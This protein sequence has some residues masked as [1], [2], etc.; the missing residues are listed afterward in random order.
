[1]SPPELRTAF[2]R[3]TRL[4]DLPVVI[5][6]DSLIAS[7]VNTKFSSFRIEYLFIAVIDVALTDPLNVPLVAVIV[8][9]CVNEKL[10]EFTTKRLPVNVITFALALISDI[11]DVLSTFSSHDALIAVKSSPISN[12]DGVHGE[13]V[14]PLFSV[15]PHI[16][17]EVI[18]LGL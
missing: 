13:A 7:L 6:S 15:I 8:P 4:T 14:S 3:I 1:M 11:N 17:V 2:P 10:S 18:L 5:P 9:S 12:V 16:S